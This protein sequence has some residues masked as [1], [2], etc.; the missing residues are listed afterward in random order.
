M[1]TLYCDKC[2]KFHEVPPSPPEWYSS[3]SVPLVRRQSLKQELNRWISKNVK[4]RKVTGCQKQWWG[5]SIE[6]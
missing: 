1:I 5:P 4:W 2:K 6:H 3:F